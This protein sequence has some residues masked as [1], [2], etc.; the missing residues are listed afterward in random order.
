MGIKISY[1]LALWGSLATL[2]LVLAWIAW[3]ASQAITDQ[4]RVP[5]RPVH[6]FELWRGKTI[7]ETMLFPGKRGKDAA[8]D[9]RLNAREVE[10]GVNYFLGRARLGRAK[11]N[12]NQT[13]L[14][15]DVSLILPPQAP[16]RFFN[17][18]VT[19]RQAA[20]G[21][22]LG[23]LHMGS[24]NLP[25]S[26]SH[27]LVRL[28]FALAPGKL[29]PALL[30]KLLASMSLEKQGKQTQLVWHG[31]S[32]RSVMSSAR[33]Q[34][35]GLKEG[36]LQPYQ[37]ALANMAEKRP[38]PSFAEVLGELFSLAR[39]RSI[40]G[41][42][43]GENR[44]LFVALAEQVNGMGS[45]ATR[46]KNRSRLTGLRLAGRGDFVEHLTL[47]AALAVVAGGEWADVAGLWKEVGD[48]ELGGSGFS[49]TDLAVDRAGTRLGRLAVA[50]AASARRVQN[51]LAGTNDESL[52]LPLVRDLPEFLPQ[53]E[54]QRRYGGV[55][56]AGTATL[57]KV[58]DRRI[59]ALPLYRAT[60]PG[61]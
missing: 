10:I 61:K 2:F 40:N 6:P 5:I 33:L 45:G 28:V 17:T 38:G 7:V 15:L 16:G 58:I 27:L 37:E 53:K 42:P 9:L 12:M 36:Q 35:L 25:A 20:S 29:D 41:D 22:E 51:L 23:T 11:V 47:S 19:L 13:G 59:D 21:L 1:R 57:F 3:I 24:A 31:A 56:G 30:D 50:S 55:N 39:Q 26:L 4:P 54:F 44:A 43:V 18:G 52:F 46:Q 32:M 14:R 60:N 8:Q 49:F 34:L 48:T